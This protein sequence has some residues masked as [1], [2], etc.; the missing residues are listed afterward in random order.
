MASKYSNTNA[1]K[2]ASLAIGILGQGYDL[3]GDLKFSN[4]KDADGKPLIEINEKE[5][6][7]LSLPGGVI[8]QNVPTMI[9]SDKGELTRFRSDIL[10][11]D[12][13]SQ[14]FNQGLSLSGKI[15]CG[16]FNSMFD[17]SG[18]WQKDASTTRHLALDGWFYTL[19]T[20]EIPRSQLILKESIKAFVPTSWE[21]AALARFLETFGTHI[22]ASVKMGGKDVVYM[23]QHQSSSSTPVEFKKLLDEVSDEWFSQGE[24]RRR[25]GS[26]FRLWSAH[27]DTFNQSFYN[28]KH[29]VTI[30][31]K[32]RGG[33]DQDQA[34]PEWIQTVPIFPDLI[35]VSLV[36][37]TSLLS[38][39]T[40]S[41]FL[42]HAINLYLRYK[43]P[44]EELHQFLDFQLPRE[45]APVFND[46]PLT[47]SRKDHSPS[48]LQFSLLGPKLKVNKMQVVVGRKP[49]TGMRLFLEGK[50]HDKIAIHLQYLSGIPKIL[51][52]LWGSHISGEPSWQ[53]PDSKNVKYFEPVQWKNFSHV[54]TAPIE[55]TETWIG[56]HVGACVVVGAQLDV[57]SFNLKNVLCLR[58]MYLRIPEARIRRSEWDHMP[59]MTTK[60]GMFSSFLSGAFSAPAATPAKHSP[61]LLNSGIYPR[62]PP[63][64]VQDPKLLKFIDTTEMTKGPQDMPGHWLVTGAKL[65]V[66]KGRIS[67][68]VKYSLLTISSD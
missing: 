66:E 35:S 29:H 36:P 62:G 9:K 42:S 63:T 23:K 54:C 20:L 48:T 8:V 41:G 3:T 58:L 38:G 45:W 17:F 40:G 57:K 37:I 67:L 14:E 43:P 47:L 31:S 11:F 21:P 34:H 68:R 25:H 13:M 32:R 55:N 49:V 56:D 12:Q 61:V 2:I 39:V 18:A 7:E 5:T 60:S 1:S 10:T 50:K 6:Y 52:P 4:C 64:S 15:P 30:M 28:K 44:I 16:L 27:L 33:I 19:Y 53:G 24:G 22:V 65:Y 59:A 26:E 46:L 51:Q